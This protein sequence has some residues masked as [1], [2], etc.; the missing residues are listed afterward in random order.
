MEVN[1]TSTINIIWFILRTRE[2]DVGQ[3]QPRSPTWSCI[4]TQKG[5]L[6]KVNSRLKTHC[7]SFRDNVRSK[8]VESCK[9]NSWN[10]N[11]IRRQS[12]IE[13]SCNF[14]RLHIRLSSNGIT[15]WPAEYESINTDRIRS[16]VQRRLRML[17][18][19]SFKLSKEYTSIYHPSTKPSVRFIRWWSCN[20]R[21]LYFLRKYLRFE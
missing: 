18:L 10:K 20:Y 19:F 13:I 7:T 12:S 3:V 8:S 9:E 14:R 17:S 1:P 2:V 4:N 16:K 6:Q 15:V 5:A 11:C 21:G